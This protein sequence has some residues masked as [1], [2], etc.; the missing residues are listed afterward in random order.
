MG[1]GTYCQVWQPV[2]EL[3]DACAGKRTN[4]LSFFL[5]FHNHVCT[6]MAEE[7]T[8]Y[9]HVKSSRQ[10]DSDLIVQVYNSSIRRSRESQVQSQFISQA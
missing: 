1:K 6:S 2:F 3:W 4:S 8:Q 7:V 10:N 9:V 5:W